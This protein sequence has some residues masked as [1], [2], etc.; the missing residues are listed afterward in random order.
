M[1]TISRRKFLS[2]SVV[3]GVAFAHAPLLSSCDNKSLSKDELQ[4]RYDKLDEVLTQPIFKKQLFPDPVII[5]TVEMLEYNNVYICRVRSKDGAEGLSVAHPFQ[6]QI[7][8]PVFQRTTR[9]FF[10]GQ[11]ARELDLLMEKFFLYNSNFRFNGV[12]LHVP[13]S[14]VEFA[15]LDMMG[16]IANKS[17]AEL[18]GEIHN[19]E[20]GVYLATEHRGLPLEEHFERIKEEVAQF[21]VNALKIRVGYMTGTKDIYYGGV[22]GKVEKLIPMVREHFGDQWAIYADANGYWNVADAIRI[23]KILEE[24]KY[25]YYEEPVMFY[26]F[27]DIKRVADALTIPIANGEQD[28]NLYTMKW[29]LAND[30]LDVVEPDMYYIGGFIRAMRMA[31]MGKAMGKICVTHMS[32]GGLGFLYNA[33]FVSALPN[34]NPHTEFKTFRT[35]VPYECPTAEMKIVNGKMKAPTG[36]GMGAVIDPE[37]IAKMRVV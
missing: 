25:A 15:L 11:D 31:L 28:H 6:T 33:M 24:Y 9:S 29:L 14:A 16:N 34:P 27:G 21:D 2:S 19:P 17:A 32:E 3:G 10:I 20:V 26:H 30:G 35:S 36:P 37:F 12:P 4:A 5:E 7:F 8:I 1:K 23:G 13:L 22:P 18:I